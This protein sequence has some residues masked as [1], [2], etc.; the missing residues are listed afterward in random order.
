MKHPLAGIIPPI[1]TPL[2]ERDALDLRGMENLVEHLIAGG[3]HGIFVLGTTGEFASLSERLKRETVER[4]CAQVKGRVPVLVGVTHT[5]FEETLGLARFAA[6]KGADAL[7]LST[8]YYFALGQPELLQYLEEILPQLPLPVFLYNIPSCTKVHVEVDT[9]KRALDLPNVAGVKDSSGNMIYYHQLVALRAQRPGWS[10]LMGPEE[11]LGES[12][13]L[14]GD[15][16]ICGGAN[17]YPGL[18]V[19]LYEAAA[20]GDL[21]RVRSLHG[22]VMQISNTLYKVGAY[23]SSFVKSLKC[24]LKVLGLC[25]DG[26]AEP[27]RAFGAEERARVESCLEALGI[28]AETVGRKVAVGV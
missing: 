12:V 26:L 23:G 21:P 2:K 22:K 1:I 16:G 3:V 14:G 25:E 4:I 8:P 24:A 19:A 5:S 20:S 10:L 11:L 6:E 27:F 17:L 7:V 15:G 18:Y 9:V 28:S 13:L